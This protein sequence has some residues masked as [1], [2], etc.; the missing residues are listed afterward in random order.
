MGMSEETERVVGRPWQPGQSGNPEGRKKGSRNAATRLAEALIEG[1]A[2]ELV[3][4]AI[5]MAK[6]GDGPILR[7]VMDRLVPARKDSPI[8][9]DLPAVETMADAKA[10]S[11]AIL[12]AVAAGEITPGEA[13]NVMGLLN[14]HRAIVETEELEARIAAL[15]AREK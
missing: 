15:E 7:A 9:L 5:E 1:E 11:S 2:E 4:K 12:A 6:N 3:K 14:T 10:A 8:E 13:A